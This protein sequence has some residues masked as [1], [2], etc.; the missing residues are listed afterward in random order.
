MQIWDFENRKSLRKIT[1]LFQNQIKDVFELNEIIRK[2]DGS[3]LTG[4]YKKRSYE[5]V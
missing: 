5:K 1:T 3:Q 2:D 4:A